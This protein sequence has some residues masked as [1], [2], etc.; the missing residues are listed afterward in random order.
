[1][2]TAVD[3]IGSTKTTTGLEVICVRDDT[4]YEL[5]QKVSDEDF[6]TININKIKPFE[7]WNY[8]ILPV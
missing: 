2:Q 8:K 5:A 4:D 3:L 7:S 6:E 1:M